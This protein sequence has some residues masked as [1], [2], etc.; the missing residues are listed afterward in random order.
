[1]NCLK[2]RYAELRIKNMIYIVWSIIL[3][4]LAFS[5]FSKV[6]MWIPIVVY[7]LVLFFRIKEKIGNNNDWIKISKRDEILKLG[8]I[9]EEMA[10]RGLT[11]S[12]HRND[13]EKKVVEDFL[14]ERRTHKRKFENELIE[15][16]FLK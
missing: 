1:M 15:S 4:L 16:L 11:F 9:A 2:Q 13:A 5:W 12:S 10:Q 8:E 14:Y 7:I 6:P 3:I